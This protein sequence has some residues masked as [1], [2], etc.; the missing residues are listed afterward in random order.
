MGI[1]F[2]SLFRRQGI[3]IRTDVNRGWVNVDCPFC[4]PRDT[5]ANGGFHNGHPAYS[6][7]RCGTHP[8]REALGRVLSLDPRQAGRLAQSFPFTGVQTARARSRVQQVEFPGLPFTEAERRYLLERKFD[9]DLLTRDYG[10]MGGGTQGRWSYR[11]LIPVFHGGSLVS[12]T[13]RSIL[14]KE[15]QKAYG[16]PRYLN[17]PDGQSAMGIKE[18]LYNADNASGD[19]VM[20]CEGPFDVLRMGRGAVCSLGT[21]ITDPQMLC[22]TRWRRVVVAFDPEPAAQAK[23][24]KIAVNLA[25]LG[26]EAEVADF[27]GDYHAE[28]PACL[29]PSQADEV[30]AILGIR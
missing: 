12:W 5:H 3:Q 13:G 27:C 14:S 4:T 29:T 2:E 25:S 15:A 22:L 1:D 17:L 24:R 23:A 21:G 6:C 19:S 28:D 26:I 7:W 30:M 16:H 11:I 18:V 9:P 8:W 20:L 10:V